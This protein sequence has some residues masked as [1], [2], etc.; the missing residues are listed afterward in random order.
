LFVFAETPFRDFRKKT[1]RFGCFFVVAAALVAAVAGA[2]VE[3][4]RRDASSL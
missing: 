4:L 2:A 3:R 1:R